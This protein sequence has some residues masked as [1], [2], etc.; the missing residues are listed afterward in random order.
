MSSTLL[1]AV[2][3]LIGFVAGYVAA[4]FFRQWRDKKEEK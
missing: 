3:I 2:R 1:I 4:H